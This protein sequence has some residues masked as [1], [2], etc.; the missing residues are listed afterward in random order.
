MNPW[1]ECQRLVA[2]IDVFD[3][4]FWAQANPV[5]QSVQVNTV[6]PGN[7]SHGW[8]PTFYGHLDNS[9]IIIENEQPRTLAGTVWIPWNKIRIL[10]SLLTPLFFDLCGFF[11]ECCIKSPRACG[12]ETS[13]TMS[14]KLSAGNALETQ[15]SVQR[16]E[17]CFST[18]A[19]HSS[20]VLTGPLN[21]NKRV[22][23]ENTQNS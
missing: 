3:L 22:A 16:N 5:K 7:M 13:S 23:S 9:V 19:R 4:D 11:S 2:S 10:D 20:L 17:F 8:A 12:S 21:W 15:T 6:S 1:L 18:A 14:H